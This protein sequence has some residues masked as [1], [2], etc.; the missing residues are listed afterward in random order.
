MP[1][2][3]KKIRNKDLYHVVNIETNKKYSKHGLP[4]EKAL[5]QLIAIEINYKGNR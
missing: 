1:F 3:I 2:K 5:K 4:Y